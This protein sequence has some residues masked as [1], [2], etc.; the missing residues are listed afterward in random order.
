VLEVEVTVMSG[1]PF[2]RLRTA[3]RG[4]R[5]RQYDLVYG[6]DWGETTTNNYGFAPTSLGSPERFQLQMYDS[7]C[8]LLEKDGWAGSG[9][10]LEIS[11]GRAGGLAH[12]A[13][14]LHASVTVGMDFS[15]VGS[16][17]CKRH[18]AAN[19]TLRFAGGDAHEL[20]FA[21]GS[22]DV[23]VDVEASNQFRDGAALFREVRRVLRPGGAFL[24]AD[25]RM[26]RMV[27]R[28][29]AALEGAG[30]QGK[31][32]DITEHV[33]R[34]CEEDTPRRLRLLRAAV[35]WPYRVLFASRMK[36]YAAVTGSRMYEKF[37]THRRKYFMGCLRKGAPV[38]TGVP[39]AIRPSPLS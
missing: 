13:T 29:E 21:D 20:P 10:V 1:G 12:L 36:S 7:L 19:E 30:L 2:R 39:H 5:R 25:S 27:A 24:F 35:P 33:R 8:E 28:V 4:S 31:L 23:V 38:R 18:Y 37:R 9:R 26:A 34:A 3:L 15:R 22:F 32:H 14:R 11:C 16:A 17:F 6:L